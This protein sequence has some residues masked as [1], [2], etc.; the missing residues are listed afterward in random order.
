LAAHDLRQSLKAP[1]DVP[2]YGKN[3]VF[4]CSFSQ[5]ESFIGVIFEKSVIAPRKDYIAKFIAIHQKLLVTPLDGVLFGS[6]NQ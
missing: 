6:E 1:A 3:F 4:D 5:K 2:L